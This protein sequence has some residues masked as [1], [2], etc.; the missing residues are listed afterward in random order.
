M[1][2]QEYRGIVNIW[3]KQPVEWHLVHETTCFFGQSSK[4]YTSI[5]PR[6]MFGSTDHCWVRILRPRRVIY[7]RERVARVSPSPALTESR[8]KVLVQPAQRRHRVVAA[9]KPCYLVIHPVVCALLQYSRCDPC[10]PTGQGRAPAAWS[11]LLHSS[12][13]WEYLR[14]FMNAVPNSGMRECHVV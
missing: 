14:S 7:A 13:L 3:L 8:G 11:R 6:R 5:R 4:K 10:D 9:R 12:S 2:K 1:P